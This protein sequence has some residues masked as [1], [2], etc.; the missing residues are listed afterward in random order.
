MFRRVALDDLLRRR[1]ATLDDETFRVAGAIVDDVRE[2]GET[3]L[4]EHAFRF[5]D[6][7]AADEPLTLERGQLERS[8][9]S[10]DAESRGVLERAAERIRRFA[11]HQRASLQDLTVC[12]PGGQAGHRFVPVE[13]AG[14]YAPGGRYPLPSSLLMTVIPARVAGVEQVIA[15]SPRPSSITQAAAAIAGA[16]HLLIIGGAQ[17]IAALSCGCA[18]L[19]PCDVIVGPG[20]RWVTAAKHVA[21]RFARIDMLAGP[22][23]LLVIADDSADPSL[24]AADL[25]AQ[26]EH[27]ED[28]LPILVALGRGTAE[29]IVEQVRR[30]LIKLPFPATARI[31]LSNG[32]W[33]SAENEEE[34][35]SISDAIAPEHLQVCTRHSEEL[36]A[37]LRHYGAI[38]I[39]ERAAEV[40]GDYG[41]GPNHT[42]PTGGVARHSA[43][44]SVL[45]FLRPLTFLRFD[46]SPQSIADAEAI[47]RDAA[48]MARMEG[49]EA[50]ARAA[51]ARITARS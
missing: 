18:G 1:A 19:P 31:A 23:E 15:A 8:L 13:V 50:H 14:C 41:I 47:A 25:L 2:R 6:L 32:G 42:L 17:A 16:D 5:G 40:F 30:R 21:S 20:N 29:R 48:A 12:V 46:D 26:A 4:R 9:S 45:H 43:G 36:A 37:R 28:A 27:D 44:L 3:A 34:A 22:S 49:L 38:F 51:E 33:I 11:Q 10:L 35:V 7:S 24:V 39:G